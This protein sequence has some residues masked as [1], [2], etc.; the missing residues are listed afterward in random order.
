MKNNRKNLLLHRAFPGAFVAFAFL[1]VVPDTLQ[2]QTQPEQFFAC[3]L[4]RFGLV[5]RIKEPGLKHRCGRRH[6]E[7]SWTALFADDDG[8]VGIG[9]TTPT[10]QLDVVGDIHA[11]G[12]LKLGNTMLFDGVANTITTGTEEDMAI[13]H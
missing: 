13:L 11:S 4:P 12:V 7:F 8:K 6:V 9:T 5:Y 10:A 2:A 3:Y 1:L